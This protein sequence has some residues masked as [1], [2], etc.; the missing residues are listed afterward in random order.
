MEESCLEIMSKKEYSKFKSY[1]SDK[2]ERGRISF[3]DFVEIVRS[4]PNFSILKPQ[5][6]DQIK[7]EL[8]AKSGFEV[9]GAVYL[10]EMDYFNYIKKVTLSYF[11]ELNEND[12]EFR[13]FFDRLSKGDETISKKALIELLQ[14]YETSINFNTFFNPIGKKTD[15][16][17]EDFCL[18]FKPAKNAN[19]LRKTF[20][21]GFATPREEPKY[22]PL[23][24]EPE[25]P[26]YIIVKKNKSGINFPITI[27][28]HCAAS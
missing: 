17:F 9:D 16:A 14:S 12:D 13:I 2:S 21:S 11:Q 22:T 8:K 6:F 3:D 23:K 15:L 7:K 10:T 20:T 1:F 18:L 27:T 19:I 4:F 25:E 26:A 24:T 5:L 28:K